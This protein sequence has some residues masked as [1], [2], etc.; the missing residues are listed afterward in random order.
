MFEEKQAEVMAPEA[1]TGSKSGFNR[2][3]FLS[4]AAMMTAGAGVVAGLEGCAGESSISSST[5]LSSWQFGIMG[6]TQWLASDDGK[7]PTAAQLKSFARS[8]VPSSTTAS[9][10]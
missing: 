10:L 6:D 8:T 9:N 4:L 1:K 2:R 5:S 7:N 3:D